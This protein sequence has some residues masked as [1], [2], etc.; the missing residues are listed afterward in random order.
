MLFYVIFIPICLLSLIYSSV[1]GSAHLWASTALFTI[2][3]SGY[4]VSVGFHRLHS[5]KSFKTYEIIR[6]LL[7]YLGCQG[8]QGSPVT[9]T[10]LHNRSHHAHTDKVGDIHTPTK[11]IFYAFIGWIFH[12][13]NHETAQKELLKI[14]KTL[15]P[16]ALWCHKN[17]NLLIIVNLLV[18][19]ALTFWIVEGMLL[20]ASL[21]ASILSIFISGIVNVVG[22]YPV[23]YLTY[24]TITLDNNSTNN[25]WLVLLTWGE[26]LHNNHHAIPRRLKFNTKWYELDIG[27]WMIWPI[28]KS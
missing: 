22:H 24:E 20:L 3:Y 27:R 28:E 5:H 25:P 1:Y 10:L 13:S 6:K 7:L 19:G 17:Y 2:L 8:S 15:D 18:I 23:K 11:G 12:K 16:F 21:N 26:S 4:G 14:R 9:W